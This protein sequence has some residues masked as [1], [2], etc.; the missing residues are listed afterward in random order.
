MKNQIKKMRKINILDFEEI[1]KGIDASF[2]IKIG[3]RKR[4]R[5]GSKTKYYAKFGYC[6]AHIGSCYHGKYGNGK[7][8]IAAIKDYCKE[9]SGLNLIFNAWSENKFEIKVPELFYKK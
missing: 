2:A 9:I 3:E 7:T 6:N 4:K 1:L 8:P 5:K